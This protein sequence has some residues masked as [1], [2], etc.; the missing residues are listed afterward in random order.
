MQ[1]DTIL[2]AAETD[3]QLLAESLLDHYYA[4]IHRLALSILQDRAEADDVAQ[5]TFITALRRI[6]SYAP[7]TNMRAWLSTIA[8]NLSRDRLRRQKIRRKW[9]ELFSSKLQESPHQSRDLEARHIRREANTFLWQTVNELNEKHRLPIILRY[10]NGFSPREIADVLQIAEGTV[11]SR[12]HNASKKL[13]T[14]LVD[15]DAESLV[16]EL[17]NE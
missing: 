14:A 1:P 16:L 10:G 15:S 11:H 4:G 3:R 2:L 6:D 9:R 17:F 7:G 8:V 5:D 12:L 13:A